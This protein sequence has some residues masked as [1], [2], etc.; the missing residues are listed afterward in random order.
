M[1]LHL[2]CFGIVA[3]GTA[4]LGLAVYSV[5]RSKSLRPAVV[6]TIK[7]GMKAADWAKEKAAAAKKEIKS[8]AAEARMPAKSSKS[9]A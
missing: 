2:R 3:A 8:L 9:K 7:G 6:G 1:S 5:V 4:L